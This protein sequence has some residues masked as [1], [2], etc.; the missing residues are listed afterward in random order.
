[1]DTG[2]SALGGIPGNIGGALCYLIGIFAIIYFIIEKEN[3][4]VKFHARQSILMHVV[5][6]SAGVV[7][8]ILLFII[9]GGVGAAA[10]DSSAASGA[11]GIFS[12]LLTL[13]WFAFLIFYVAAFIFAGVK[14]Y[15]GQLYKLPIIGNAA[16]KWTN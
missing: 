5:L 14:A 13:I 2:K 4:F 7:L 8:R 1:M 11:A 10:S 16:E 15:Q 3:R 6:V 12:L 9:G